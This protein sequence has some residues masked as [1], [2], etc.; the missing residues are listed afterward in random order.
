M[1]RERPV[2]P[3][4]YRF[5][6]YRQNHVMLSEKTRVFNRVLESKHPE[7]QI[8]TMQQEGVF[9]DFPEH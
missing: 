7:D 9:P 5:N 4:D 1:F 6:E 8:L 2:E 3:I